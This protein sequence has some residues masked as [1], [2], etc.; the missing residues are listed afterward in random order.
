LF[1]A[2][3]T[4]LGVQFVMEAEDEPVVTDVVEFLPRHAVLAPHL[5]EAAAIGAISDLHMIASTLAFGDPTDSA[6]SR[7]ISELATN[8]DF[9]GLRVLAA[10]LESAQGS[11]DAR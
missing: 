8:F 3:K 11:S 10:S 2:L 1:S 5:R 4:H 9:E 6:L 7:R